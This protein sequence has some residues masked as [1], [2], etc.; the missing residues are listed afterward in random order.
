MQFL[1]YAIITSSLCFE[2]LGDQG[3]AP[4]FIAYAQELLAIVAVLVVVVGGVQQ[5]FGN[6]AAGYWFVF[7][8]LAVTIV[9]GLLTNGVESGSTFA[10][11]ACLPACHS[12]I[13]PA[14]RRA[15]LATASQSSVA[16][17]AGV[18]RRAVADLAR[19][20]SNYVC[21]ADSSPA[22][23]RSG[24]CPTLAFLSIF[25]IGV[26]A[27]LFAFFVRG[28]LSRL[29]A[30]IL[31]PIVLAPT[32]FNETKASLFLVPLALVAVVVVGATKNRWRKFMVA[33]MS[34]AVFL[35]AFVPIYDYFMKPRYGYGI[36]EF[37]TME[38]RVEDY[39]TRDA[40]V[41][42]YEAVGKVDAILVPL[43]VLSRDPSLLAFGLGIG[44]VSDSALGS[45]FSGEHFQRYGHFVQ[46]GVSMLLWETGVLGT[47]LVFALLA[48]LF[49]DALHVSRGDDFMAAFALGMLGVI[50]AIAFSLPYSSVMQS[51]ALSYLFWYA[52]GLVAAERGRALV[53]AP[54]MQRGAE[55]LAV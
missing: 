48:M 27:V 25:L 46:S 12:A 36:V 51:S 1:V 32:T 47:G 31:L 18:C 6:V 42:S 41:G 52:A 13:L 14:C 39:L 17:R 33:S 9:C 43:R 7:G 3:Y 20:A 54:Q 28:R 21:T 45:Q 30:F 40:T 23:E 34:T 10:G 26:A 29:W 15:L 49:L 4:S 5:R 16:A 8:A 11:L 37:F 24:R 44:S 53:R 22:I 19:T 35:V 50:G 38:G 55:P 2:Y